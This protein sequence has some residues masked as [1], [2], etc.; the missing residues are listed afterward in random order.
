MPT[1]PSA[2]ERVN[3]SRPSTANTTAT[4][5]SSWS[6]SK[7]AIPLRHAW[8]SGPPRVCPPA[9]PL[10]SHPTERLTL[11]DDDETVAWASDEGL[12]DDALK[13]EANKETERSLR[14]I[15]ENIK[16][17]ADR[18][19]MVD[20]ETIQEVIATNREN[21]IPLSVMKRTVEAAEPVAEKAAATP[22][23]KEILAAG[24][25]NPVRR[26][27]WLPPGH[28]PVTPSET[29]PPRAAASTY[30]TPLNGTSP[31]FLQAGAPIASSSKPIT[32][33]TSGLPPLRPLASILAEVKEGGGGASPSSSSAAITTPPGGGGAQAEDTIDTTATSAAPRAAQTTE[34]L[35]TPAPPSKATAEGATKA[36]VVEEEDDDNKSLVTL[37]AE[38]RS[39]E[40]TPLKA[41]KAG[42]GAARTPTTPSTIP[43][44]STA[45]EPPM[46]PSVYTTPSVTSATKPS[47]QQSLPPATPNSSETPFEARRRA[48]AERRIAAAR[49]RA[50]VA[51]YIEQESNAI[52]A[53]VNN[54]GQPPAPIASTAAATPPPPVPVTPP[55]PRPLQPQQPQQ[56]Q[57]AVTISRSEE[58]KPPQPASRSGWLP[59]AP[60]KSN[61]P[62]NTKE[63]DMVNRMALAQREAA[64]WGVRRR[65]LT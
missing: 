29:P 16:R 41:N 65:L 34:V 59:P 37:R 8:T 27:D 33:I 7:P 21:M 2:A 58:P 48:A 3:T 57:P 31:L 20:D 47:H 15:R 10:S 62:M 56:P 51:R 25:T 54:S 6:T 40:E 42:G 44:L 12:D 49:Q 26:A 28:R 38:M 36:V 22:D 32:S 17:A 35:F 11:S 43:P 52:A 61:A 30:R 45:I 13:T 50:E 53:R 14:E 23:L 60:N 46:T 24:D 55:P 5:D 39:R 19:R 63:L 4:A 64:H 18:C 9:I 1:L